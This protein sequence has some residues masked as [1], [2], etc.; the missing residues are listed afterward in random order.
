MS[1]RRQAGNI[2]T[3]QRRSEKRRCSVVAKIKESSKQL[4]YLKGV[5]AQHCNNPPPGTYAE[6]SRAILG[7]TL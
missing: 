2:E 7:N 3:M 5:E 4:N 6:P 1:E